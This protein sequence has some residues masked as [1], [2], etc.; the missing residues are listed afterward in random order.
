MLIKDKLRL[1]NGCFMAQHCKK[2]AIQNLL[3][4]SFRN[5]DHRTLKSNIGFIQLA[6]IS[7]HDYSLKTTDI[8]AQNFV[9]I[10]K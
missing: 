5:A 8:H 6:L 4:G 10:L 2:P 3:M 7:L 9:K 1:D